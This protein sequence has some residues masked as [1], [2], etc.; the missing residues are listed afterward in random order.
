MLNTDINFLAEVL[1][2]AFLK[3]DKAV[4]KLFIISGLTGIPG[5]ILFSFIN[6]DVIEGKGFE[7]LALAL[8]VI[9]AGLLIVIIAYQRVKE[10]DNEK[11]AIQKKE[12]ELEKSPDRTKAAWDLARIKLESY[13]NRNISQVRWIFIWT[14]LVMI[15][16]FAIISFGIFKVYEDPENFQPSILVTTVGVITELIGATFLIVYKSTMNQA[17]QYVAVLERINAVG[18]SVQILESI[19]SEANG[20]KDKTKSELV[21]ELLNLYGKR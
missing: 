13:L 4:T 8:S 5:V 19:E 17:K 6:A 20:L 9:G 12:E 3:R 1:V 2:K 16:G 11:A 7:T 14:V 21:K 10:V 15:I 18:M